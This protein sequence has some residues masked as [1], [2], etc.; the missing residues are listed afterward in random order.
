LAAVI[1]SSLNLDKQTKQ[2]AD[3][4]KRLAVSD[5]LLQKVFQFDNV[6]LNIIVMTLGEIEFNDVFLENNLD[7]FHVDVRIIL[8]IFLFL[9]PIVLMNLLV[10]PV[11]SLVRVI[12]L[13]TEKYPR[14][15][16]SAGGD[17]KSERFVNV[18]INKNDK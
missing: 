16:A 15:T 10:R 17:N 5:V 18:M 2:S 3:G 14:N 4:S 7:P 1:G 11:F 12:S 6:F 8:F 9:M 13:V